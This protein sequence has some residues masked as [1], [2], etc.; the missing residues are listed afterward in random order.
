MARCSRTELSRTALEGLA[1]DRA[2]ADGGIGVCG[3]P[4]EVGAVAD[5]ACAEGALG[6]HGGRA[7]GARGSRDGRSRTGLAHEGGDRGGDDA[8]HRYERGRG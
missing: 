5:E 3:R 4:L 2:L 1:A 7:T 8:A 6:S